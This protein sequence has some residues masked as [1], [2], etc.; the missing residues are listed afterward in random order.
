MRVNIFDFL[1]S[2]YCI[3]FKNFPEALMM[4]MIMITNL[5]FLVIYKM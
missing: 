3:F 2:H 1:S 4:T 5:I